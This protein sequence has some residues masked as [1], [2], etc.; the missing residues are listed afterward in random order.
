MK[1]VNL[2]YK[3]HLSVTYFFKGP[4]R[5]FLIRGNIYATCNV[6]STHAFVFG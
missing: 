3:Y 2:T 4:A 1:S 6:T 5:V